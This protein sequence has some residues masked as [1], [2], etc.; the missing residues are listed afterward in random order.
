MTLHCLA[1]GLLQTNCY[2]LATEQKNALA[3][4]PGGEPER[5]LAFLKEK[6][7]TLRLMAFTHGHFDHIGAAS[8]LQDET[9]AQTAVPAGDEDIFCNPA[10]GGSGLFPNF[11]GYTPRRPDILYGD[12]D[13]ITLD[14]ISLTALHTPGHT[15]GSSVL[16]GEGILFSGDTLFAGSCGRTDLYGGDERQILQS[17]QKIAALPG[18]WRVLPGHGP[19]TALGVER[20]SNPYMGTNYDNL[21]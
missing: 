5:L 9:G 3:V 11:N 19:E 6:G 14:G 21:F 1:L 12:G 16:C 10:L 15:K 18:D 20:K 2:I 17:L 7:L 8:R 4:D 13:R